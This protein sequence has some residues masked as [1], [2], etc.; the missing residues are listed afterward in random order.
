MDNK[1]IKDL[2]VELALEIT[3][4]CEGIEGRPVFTEQ[5]LKACTAIGIK[6][7]QSKFSLNGF[8]FT[9]KTEAALDAC[10]ETEYWLEI[11]CKVN[12]ID[13]AVFES[14]KEKCGVIR[15]KLTVIVNAA[16]N[17]ANVKQF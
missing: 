15:G 4:I 8:D 17:N 1:S 9:N 7:H 6:S 16:K 13:E 14:L 2:A 10:N 3:D 12:A 11:L 5:L